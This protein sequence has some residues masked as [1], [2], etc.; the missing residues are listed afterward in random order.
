MA[1]IMLA[2]THAVSL[3]SRPGENH[4]LGSTSRNAALGLFLVRSSVQPHPAHTLSGAAKPTPV[5]TAQ[6]VVGAFNLQLWRGHC[7]GKEISWR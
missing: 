3:A 4:G 7:Q 5:K 1:D 6:P 2:D